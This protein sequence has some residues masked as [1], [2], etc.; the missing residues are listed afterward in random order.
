MAII[1]LWS[2]GH[3][4]EPSSSS[5]TGADTESRAGKT[6]GH[7][8]ARCLA[9]DHRW[10]LLGPAPPYPARGGPGAAATPTA[11]DVAS[12][13]ASPNP[14]EGIGIAA[15]GAQNVVKTLAMPPLKRK[16]LAVAY[17]PNC[18]SRVKSLIIAFYCFRGAGRPP[19]SSDSGVVGVG[20]VLDHHLS[21][22]SGAWLSI[23]ESSK[24][25]ATVLRPPP[26]LAEY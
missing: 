16:H 17:A 22:R 9:A 24:S 7:S 4:E 14:R 26:A 25:V 23:R 18:E 1:G 2:A 8:D 12:A 10:S 15:G 6:G 5:G 19:G 21:R 13:T 20:L 3:A 11:A